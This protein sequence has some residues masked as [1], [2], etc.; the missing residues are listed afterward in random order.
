M[1]ATNGALTGGHWLL[2][3]GCAEEAGDYLGF[4]AELCPEL[5]PNSIFCAQNQFVL[6]QQKKKKKRI[7][8]RE[9]ACKW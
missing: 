4:S 9:S 6:T 1:L 8:Q 2:P 7:K 5:S 3:P